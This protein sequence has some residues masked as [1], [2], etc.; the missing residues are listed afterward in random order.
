MADKNELGNAS[1]CSGPLGSLLG[2]TGDRTHTAHAAN[3]QHAHTHTA[4][5][6]EWDANANL[7]GSVDS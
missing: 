3:T 7:A 2:V 6:G 1:L 5:A 4:H